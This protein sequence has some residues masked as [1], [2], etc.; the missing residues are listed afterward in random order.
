MKYV[1][2][3]NREH[4]LPYVLVLPAL[5]IFTI[6]VFIPFF[7]TVYLSFFDWNMIKPV[8]NFVGWK[9]YLHILQDPLTWI[10][11]KNTAA[12]LG[13]LLVFNCAA[14][15]GLAFVLSFV[16]KRGQGFYKGAFFLPSVISLVVGSILYLWIL[17]PVSGPAAVVAHYLGIVL[18]VWS[19]T[20]GWVIVV[21]SLITTWKVF[22]YNFI[23]ILGGVAGVSQEIIEAAKIDD[24][25]LYRIFWDLVL[26]MS[27]ATGVY[28]FIMTIVQGLQYVFTPIKVITQG[29][30]DNGSSNIV[31]AVYQEAFVLY[32]TGPAAAL[33]I[34]SM[35]LFLL[36]FFLEFKYV[37]K[38]VYYEH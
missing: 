13:I 29:G 17:N 36:L 20:Q 33:S 5:L 12:Y 28:I 6:F 25:P 24:V 14:P 16:I 4:W 23:V 15:Y 11:L 38:G 34:L 21:L 35:G 19:I 30:P 2:W 18:P 31:Y 22:G 1:N 9:N 8:K 3:K 7:Y 37:E 10:I 26:P 32:H 27:S